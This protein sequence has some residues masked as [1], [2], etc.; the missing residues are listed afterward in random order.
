MPSNLTES[1]IQAILSGPG[2]VDCPI[3]N[4]RIPRST[5]QARMKK[6]AIHNHVTER[7]TD[8]IIKANG[9]DFSRCLTCRNLQTV[10]AKK[11]KALKVFS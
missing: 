11:K 8:F 5:C 10:G 3:C 4:G 7:R 1:D 6:A 9:P 2:Y